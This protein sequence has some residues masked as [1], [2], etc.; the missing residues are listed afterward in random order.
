M[1]GPL[2]GGDNKKNRNNYLPSVSGVLLRGV[3]RGTCVA[4]WVCRQ[5]RMWLDTARYYCVS[6]W[7]GSKRQGSVKRTQLS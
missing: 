2:G 4:R 3:Q 6:N 1:R 5:V 7:R